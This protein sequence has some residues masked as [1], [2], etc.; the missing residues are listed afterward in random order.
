MPAT[1]TIVNWNIQNY[2]PTKSGQRYGNRDV[3]K[4][5][6][7]VVNDVNA[8][9]FVLLEVNTTHVA[10]ARQVADIMRAELREEALNPDTEWRRYVL[11]PNTGVEFYAFF[12]RDTSYT[13]PLPIVGPVVAGAVPTILG[14]AGQAAVTAA[15]FDAV[16][17]QNLRASQFPL[18]SP[19]RHQYIHGHQQPVPPWPGVRR[20]VLGLFWVPTASAAN[21]LL[22]IVACH[23]AA[24]SW[25]AR[26]QFNNLPYFSLLRAL[27]PA[28][29]PPPPPN[30]PPAP[31]NPVQ[32]N[33]RPPGGGWV[34]HAANYYVLLGDF[35]VDFL[36]FPQDY[37]SIRGTP[38]PR[39]GATQFVND[40]THLVTYYRYSPRDFHTT[41][42]L[43]INAY[44]DIFCRTTP[45]VVG[46]AGAQ[47]QVMNIPEQVR[48]REL[49]L[50]ASVDHYRV[51]DQRGFTSDAYN[52]LVY[53]YA[54]QLAGDWSHV[55]NLTGSLVGGRLISDHLPVVWDIT[56]G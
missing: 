10:T 47:A 34:Q 24:Q 3:V 5:I 8:D 48:T 38:R 7:K 17:G 41:A 13:R 56:I 29:P 20:P 35:N 23:F 42:E 37:G 25:L 43:A 45:T 36:A 15:Q 49:Q 30:P 14:G 2:G 1:V 16:P 33:V 50:K 31:P 12:V 18:L 4:A 26:A 52:E 55:I 27:A 19:D 21:R 51:L 11:S 40:T 44:D 9:I 53:D 6:A 28:P 39:L 46:V 22:P 54:R 32:L